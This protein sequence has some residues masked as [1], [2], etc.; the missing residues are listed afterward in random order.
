MQLKKLIFRDNLLTCISE[1]IGKL[2]TLE[3]LDVSY[4]YISK[5]TPIIKEEY[6]NIWTSFSN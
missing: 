1:D 5:I 3:Y 2:V 6:P 4:N